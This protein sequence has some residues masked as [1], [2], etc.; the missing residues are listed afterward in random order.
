MYQ[1]KECQI[2]F[3]GKCILN[4]FIILYSY[5]EIAE[6]YAVT[7]IQDQFCSFSLKTLWTKGSYAHNYKAP[8]QFHL[9]D[10]NPNRI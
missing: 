8:L 5:K 7:G 1:T 10:Y 2:C 6:F 3:S 4:S 9:Y